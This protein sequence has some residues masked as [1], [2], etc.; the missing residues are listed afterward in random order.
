[1]RIALVC[2]REHLGQSRGPEEK[3]SRYTVRPDTLGS[4]L[5]CPVWG[6]DIVIIDRAHLP[7][8][9]LMSCNRTPRLPVSTKPEYPHLLVR[10]IKEVWN[11]AQL[12]Q[13]LAATSC[14]DCSRFHITTVLRPCLKFSPGHAITTSLSASP[15]YANALDSLTL[16]STSC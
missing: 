15:R 11:S 5:D 1:M 14:G 12:I 10:R 13:S 6:H 4:T 7:R 9:T 16:A 3:A 2:I 8:H